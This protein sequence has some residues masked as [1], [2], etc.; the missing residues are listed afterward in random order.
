[1]SINKKK[2][3]QVIIYLCSK[4]G[5]EI[6]GKKKLAKLLYFADF[7][8]FEKFQKPITGDI[9]KAYPKGP[10]PV[11]LNEI[12]TAMSK[13]GNLKIDTVQEWGEEYAPTEVYKCSIKADI[14]VF[15]K[16]EI[17]ML[18]R[19]AHLYGRFN[20][21]KLAILSHAEAPYTAAEPYKEIPYEFT[22]YRGTD[23]SDL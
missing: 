14:S 20:G 13:K 1:M 21:E 10:V 6:R 4:L 12:I 3:E 2:Y 23:F 18:N 7:D 19:I 8:Y 9:Y 15:T 22:Y 17:K 5:G 16:N 11:A